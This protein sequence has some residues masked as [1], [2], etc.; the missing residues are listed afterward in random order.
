MFE[1]ETNIICP[2]C[3]K[4]IVD[5]NNDFVECEHLFS[6]QDD[7]IDWAEFDENI[8]A[9]FEI[10]EGYPMAESEYTNDIKSIVKGLTICKHLDITGY[11]E[12]NIMAK[13]F[14]Q[15][16]FSNM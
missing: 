2:F 8:Y 6:H 14:L 7:G 16:T 5:E 10:L 12:P 3:D 9:I 4:I 1:E 11:N 13:I 15:N